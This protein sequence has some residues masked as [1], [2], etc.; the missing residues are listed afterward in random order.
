MKNINILLVLLSLFLFSCPMQKYTTIKTVVEIQTDKPLSDKGLSALSTKI[1]QRL[2]DFNFP[3]KD[4]NLDKGKKQLTI[5]ADVK[6]EDMDTYNSIFDSHQL[7]FWDTFRTDDFQIKQIDSTLLQVEGFITDPPSGFSLLP[8]ELGRCQ[9]ADKLSDIA[10][11]LQENLKSVKHLKLIWSVEQKMFDQKEYRLYMI[12]TQ[13]KTESPLTEQAIKDTQVEKGSY[14]DYSIS[15]KFDEAGTKTWT[16]M[17][18]NA[19]FNGNRS[20]AIVLD[21]QIVMCP[22]V[23]EPIYGGSCMISG[24]YTKEVAV[25]LMKKLQMGRLPYPLKIL[26]QTVISKVE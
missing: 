24:S 5:I 4:L 13:G 25:D 18:Q 16:N 20:I 15:F 3:I 26:E 21:G 14:G 12:D 22:K 9:A 7:D 2:V 17:T 10:L 11:Q 1:Q 19:A 8:E 23:M 6:E